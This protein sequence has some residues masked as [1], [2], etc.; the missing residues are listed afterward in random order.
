MDYAVCS[1][2]A[3]FKSIRICRCYGFCASSSHT[4][5]TKTR[6]PIN[7]TDKSQCQGLDRKLVEKTAGSLLYARMVVFSSQAAFQ[8]SARFLAPAFGWSVSVE[9]LSSRFCGIRQTAI[10]RNQKNGRPVQVVR[11]VLCFTLS[12]RRRSRRLAGRLRPGRWGLVPAPGAGPGRRAA[13]SARGR[14]VP[15]PGWPSG[16]GSG[17]RFG[18][19]T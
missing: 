5:F 19:Q 6:P 1:W 16:C 14:P 3:K 12:L 17:H 2:V 13:G 8:I 9:R 15:L 4:I 10:I 18:R 7:R 11:F